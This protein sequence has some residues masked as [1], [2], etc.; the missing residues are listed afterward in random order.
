MFTDCAYMI[1]MAG[2]LQKIAYSFCEPP[3]WEFGPY[4][5]S[6]QRP[7]PSIDFRHLGQANV[8]WVDGHVSSHDLDF[9]V[10]YQT[11]SLITGEE[12]KGQGIGWFGNDSN[13]LFDL[14]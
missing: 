3:F 7:N 10:S 8:A 1:T 11:H 14:E 13:E 5:P 9:S 4:G 2:S 6:N 12:A